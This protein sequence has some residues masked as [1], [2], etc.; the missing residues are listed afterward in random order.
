MADNA[1]PFAY[2]VAQALGR[3]IGVPVEFVVDPPWPQREQM[4]YDGE[5]HVAWLCGLPYVREAERCDPRIDLL[6][7]PVMRQARYGAQPVYFTDVVVRRDHRAQAL[8]DLHGASVAI[9]EPN[10]HSGYQVLR[11]TLAEQGLPT[12]FFRE[13]IESGAHQRSL[14]LIE[15]GEVDAAPTDT[16]V[17]ETEVR[18]RPQLATRLAPALRQRLRDALLALGTDAQ[19][20]EALERADVQGFAAVDENWYAPIRQ[21][22]LSAARYPLPVTRA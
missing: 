17:L 1:E 3:A 16:T 13:V 15:S 8:A 9:N 5:V 11:H 10:S 22:S 18:A 12:G 21:M 19:A 6:A 14:E 2:A 7:A 4:L 20:R